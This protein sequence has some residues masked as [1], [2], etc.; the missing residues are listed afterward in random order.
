MLYTFSRELYHSVLRKKQVFSGWNIF[1][2]NCTSRVIFYVGL[3]G[4]RSMAQGNEP[5]TIF[6]FEM[7]DIDGKPVQLN[8]YRGFVSLI[9][10]V[11]SA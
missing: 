3:A 4:R 8:K 1:T 9:V 11:A 2:G 5:K 7:K 10:N 6:D